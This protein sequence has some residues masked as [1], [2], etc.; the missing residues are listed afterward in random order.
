MYCTAVELMRRFGPLELAQVG[1]AD[2]QAVVDADL[3]RATLLVMDRS[4]WTA[5][6][7]VV[8]DEAAV[9]IGEA[10]TDADQMVDG[11]LAGRYTLP[12]DPVPTLLRRV[13]AD[14]AR[15]LLHED[16]ATEDIQRRYT[17]AVKLLAGLRKGEVTLG[18]DDP[19]PATAGAPEIST[20]G[21]VFT[22][23]TLADFGA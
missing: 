21:R 10:L 9:R 22:R 11:Y 17:D 7:I 18:V 20:P 4:A 13:G 14:I 15:Y 3:L 16:R 12:F 19:S 6:E 1:S 8:A 23:D 2:D 5:P